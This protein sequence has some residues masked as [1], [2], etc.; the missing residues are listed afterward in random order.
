MPLLYLKLHFPGKNYILPYFSNPNIPTILVLFQRTELEN[1]LRAVWVQPKELL[2]CPKENIPLQM[3][4]STFKSI[5]FRSNRVLLEHLCRVRAFL[6][7]IWEHE[8][9]KTKKITMSARARV[10]LGDF[11]PPPPAAEA[12]IGQPLNLLLLK[13]N[14]SA[15]SALL[16]LW[17]GAVSNWCW[18]IIGL[19]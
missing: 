17:G 11:A 13:I 14:C 18:N 5:R 10:I 3:S 7:R 9:R 8:L 4:S 6:N 19:Y 15:S 16:V 1:G 2:L 12:I